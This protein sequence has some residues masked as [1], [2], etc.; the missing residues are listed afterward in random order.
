MCRQLQAPCTGIDDRV[1][2]RPVD[3]HW[4]LAPEGD[5]LTGVRGLVIACPAALL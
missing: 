1:W 4:R 2:D 5:N 3:Q